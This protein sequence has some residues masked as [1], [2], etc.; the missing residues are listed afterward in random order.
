[1]R[2]SSLCDR[3]TLDGLADWPGD[4]SFFLR[5]V[6]TTLER[7]LARYALVVHLRTPPA[8]RGY[9]RN[10]LRIESALEAAAID[11]RIALAWESHP[12]RI[13]A[14]SSDD[15]VQKVARTIAVLR[16]AS[17]GAPALR[18]VR[19]CGRGSERRLRVASVTMPRVQT[20]LD[21]ETLALLSRELEKEAQRG[22]LLPASGCSVVLDGCSGD[23]ARSDLVSRLRNKLGAY[24]DSDT[25][26][27]KVYDLNINGNPATI[28]I[29]PG[30]T[31]SPETGARGMGGPS[32]T[33]KFHMKF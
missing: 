1:M 15:F 19:A 12:R 24:I 8:A 14:E 17:S 18:R 2:A 21:P 27:L 23:P 22:K 5:D 29:V 32:I 7:E 31:S 10:L 16:G 11:E 6:G 28:S 25:G 20:E 33:I 26:G 9:E 13:V 30:W 4:A 3:R